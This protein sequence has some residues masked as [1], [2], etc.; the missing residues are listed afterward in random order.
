MQHYDI[1]VER[2]TRCYDLGIV[3]GVLVA[4]LGACWGDRPGGG[5]VA[6]DQEPFLKDGPGH[7]LEGASTSLRCA[8]VPI[9][10][11]ALLIGVAGRT[12]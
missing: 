6:A 8:G 12:A 3:D 1:S 4:N 9:F 2:T 7:P 10:G 11:A 5:W